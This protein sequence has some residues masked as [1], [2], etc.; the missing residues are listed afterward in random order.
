MQENGK[1]LG[2]GI[3]CALRALRCDLPGRETQ[4]SLAAGSMTK[5]FA[6]IIGRE[7]ENRGREREKGGGRRPN[8]FIPGS[9]HLTHAGRGTPCVSFRDF[10]LSHPLASFSRVHSQ[11]NEN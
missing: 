3:E 2:P 8:T 6:L 9:D 5:V 10:F 11:K 1:V 4:W 7:K